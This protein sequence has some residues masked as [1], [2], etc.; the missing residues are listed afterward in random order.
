MASLKL[1]YGGSIPP[2]LVVSS[3]LNEGGLF[4]CVVGRRAAVKSFYV[5]CCYFYSLNLSLGGKC[6]PED[7]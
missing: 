4:K 5:G 3:N 1:A 7:K 6:F 2:F